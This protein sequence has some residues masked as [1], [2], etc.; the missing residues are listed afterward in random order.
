MMARTKVAYVAEVA[1]SDPIPDKDRIRY[2]TL[3]DLGWQVIAPASLSP[4]DKV[5]YIEY[6]TL[7]TP[8]PWSEFLRK[9]CWAPKYNA[10]KIYAMKMAGF[11]SCGL[12]LTKEDLKDFNIDW[13]IGNDVSKL[14]GVQAI[15]ECDITSTQV[16]TIEKSQ[17]RFQR[18]IKKYSYFLWKFFWGK[19]RAS[20]NFPS[21][22]ANKTDETRIETMTYLFGEEHQGKPVY[23]T[24]K[25]DGQ[26]HTEMIFKGRFIIASRNFTKYDKP[27]KTAIRELIPQNIDK[28]GRF[29]DHLKIACK[30]STALRMSKF[31]KNLTFQ[32]ELCGPGI[33]KNRIGLKDL[34]LYI[35]NLYDPGNKRFYGWPDIFEFADQMGIPTVPLLDHTTW[36]WRDMAS[37]KDY[38]KGF[39]ESGHPQEGIVIRAKVIGGQFQELPERGMSNQ[40]SVKVI[41]NDFIAKDAK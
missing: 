11:I 9:R 17:S 36:Q 32:A 24:Q 2:I 6:D 23:V 38:A 29:D 41:N 22:G 33:Q 7:V 40:W 19:N 34:K 30:Y 1:T 39:Y 10:F 18:F 12:V 13:T 37:I 28:L 31:K 14:L 5:V 35:F 8:A 16:S 21:F 27:L 25:M 4:G 3:R 20:G 15:E 26:S